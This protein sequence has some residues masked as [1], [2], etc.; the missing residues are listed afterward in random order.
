MVWPLSIAP[1]V[2]LGGGTGP[3]SFFKDYPGIRIEVAEIDPMVVEVAKE[4]FALPDD[5]RLR[6]VTSDG[7]THLRRTGRQ[8]GAI[9]MDAYG[10]GRYGTAIPF[11]L[12][13]REFFEIA[14]TRLVN[15]GCLVY[16]VMGTYTG[17]N[18]QT[19][20]GI[21]ATLADVFEVVYVF[22]ALSS[23]NTVLVAQKID[24]GQLSENG[25][26]DGKGW[27]EGPWLDHPLGA[28]EL[29]QLVG[30]LY[31][32][33]ILAQT[34]FARRVTQLSPVQ[35]PPP[36]ALILTDN[37]APVDITPGLRRSN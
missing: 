5:P 30:I 12:A 15:G 9:F 7:R 36:G 16:N 25:T 18:R 27:P 10:V 32:R 34:G 26:R 23:G 31:D 4:Y 37:F 1:Q 19:L 3:K 24:V 8:Y 11:H 6:I 28:Q 22:Q 13:T 2:G 17:Q 29:S 20:S 35:V 21:H 14:R 33:G